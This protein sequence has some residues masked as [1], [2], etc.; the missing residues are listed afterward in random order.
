MSVRRAWLPGLGSAGCVVWLAARGSARI[1]LAADVAELP[2]KID[3]LAGQ[4]WGRRGIQPGALA[5][6]AEFLRRAY[7]DVAGR[8]PSVS[9]T[10]AYLKTHARTPRRLVDQLAASPR[11]G[12]RPLHQRLFGPS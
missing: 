12:G 11:Y 4:G 1:R 10:Q 2:K 8:I 5:D 3:Q 6:D 9:E 7:L